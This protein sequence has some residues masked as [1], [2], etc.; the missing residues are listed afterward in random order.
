MPQ[1]LKLMTTNTIN[2]NSKTP[3][4]VTLQTVNNPSTGTGTFKSGNLNKA[5]Y[6]KLAKLI[7]SYINSNGKAPSTGTTSLGK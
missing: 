1:F 6:V 3:K 4:S 2:L 5:T 7:N